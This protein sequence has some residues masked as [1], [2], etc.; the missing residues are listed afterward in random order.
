MHQ[1]LS[2]GDCC[3]HL[4][5]DYVALMLQLPADWIF[6][7]NFYK[8]MIYRCIP[9]LR[10]VMYANTGSVLPPAMTDYRSRRRP[11][12]SRFSVR[13]MLSKPKSLLARGARRVRAAPPQPVPEKPYLLQVLQRDQDLHRRVRRWSTSSPSARELLDPDKT[14][15]FV[16]RVAQDRIAP[17]GYGPAMECFGALAT[18]C[19]ADEMLG[20]GS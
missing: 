7:R 18:L 3:P 10:H 13:S 20:A 1:S 17:Q 19:V 6:Q 8:Y 4:G 16:D 9:G 2:R 5:Y 14:V 11:Q 12:A 15:S